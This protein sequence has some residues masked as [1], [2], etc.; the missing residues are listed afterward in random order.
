MAPLT[1][2]AVQEE[3]AVLTVQ[4]TAARVQRGDLPQ[5]RL[6]SLLGVS[7]NSVID[8]ESG[9]ESLTVR[10]LIVWAR[11]LMLRLVIVDTLGARVHLPLVRDRGE[12]WDT[13]ELRRLIT[14]LRD[15]RKAGDRLTQI[16]VA[17]R[18]GVG[19]TSLRH[20]ETL[21]T[22]PRTFSLIRWAMA[23]DCGIRLAPLRPPYR[24]GLA[25]EG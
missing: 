16:E 21:T 23:L 14:T 13:Y 8:W 22:A 24:T 9:R 18:A 2:A 5:H 6:A 17:R 12:D 19:Q 15:I 1:D 25:M 20:W 11:A 4:L 7:T 10:H 3:V